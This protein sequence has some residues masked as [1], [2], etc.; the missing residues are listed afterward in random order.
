MRRDLEP[1]PRGGFTLIELLGV[2]VIVSIL[3]FF[4]ITRLSGVDESVKM[5]IAREK[6][7]QIAAAL[8]EYE[9]DRGDWPRSTFHPD[10]GQPPN[11]L[12]LGG[13]ALY[14]ALWQKGV[15]G[16]GISEDLLCNSDGD[17]TSKRLTVNPSLELFELKDPW[18]N[19][20][21]YF[22]HSDYGRKDTYTCAHPETG[23]PLE[24][25]ATAS[26][27]SKTG[28]WTN[29]HGFQLVSSGPDAIF[30]TEDDIGNFGG[31]S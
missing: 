22:H 9:V 18:D 27:S 28:N 15:E 16:Q 8:S 23:E 3:M 21:A 24:S 7:E 17:A 30:G 13:E 6:I 1:T 26:K 12:N 19:P 29:P 5:R 11:G 14:L 4:L 10:W 2:I 31:G 25:E 20:M